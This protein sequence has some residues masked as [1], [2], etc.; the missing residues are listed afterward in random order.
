ML[1]SQAFVCLTKTQS[2][3]VAASMLGKFHC[4]NMSH[5]SHISASE[6]TDWL[7]FKYWL[8][9]PLVFQNALRA[10]F[11]LHDFQRQIGHRG[12]NSSTNLPSINHADWQVV[13]LKKEVRDQIWMIEC[14]DKERGFVCK[15]VWFH[16]VHEYLST[17]GQI[18]LLLLF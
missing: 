13:E 14:V 16:T 3:E 11:N 7:I 5:V 10:A 17:R 12:W 2:V 6:D 18:H 9:Y 4:L 8:S 1:I 15:C